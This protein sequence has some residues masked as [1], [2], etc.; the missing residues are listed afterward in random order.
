MKK[1][2]SATLLLFIAIF[3]SNCATIVSK[4]NWPF[5]VDTAPQGANVV[6]T[7]RKGIEVFNGKSPATMTL[8]SGSS[9][10]TK[11]SYTVAL[12]MEGY[13]SKKVTV[14]CRVNGWYFGNLLIGGVIG[15]LIVDPA[16]GAMYRLDAAGISEKLESKSS[17]GA[18]RS[19]QILDLAQLSPAQQEKLVRIK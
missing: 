10:F 12:G 7:N 18:T 16:T 8:K 17:T 4:S 6:I 1:I 9:F 3:F 11:E 14:E 19:L 5:T 2:H 15:M 13:E